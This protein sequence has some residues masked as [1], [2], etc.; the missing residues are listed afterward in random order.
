MKIMREFFSENNGRLSSMRLYCF[1]S[2]LTSIGISF[3]GILM[4]KTTDIFSFTVL[5]L[6]G[7]FA[8]KSIQKFAEQN[9]KD[10]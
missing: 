3:Y 10:E 5:Y 9:K 6:V 8:P 4:N 1:I 2:L 7:A